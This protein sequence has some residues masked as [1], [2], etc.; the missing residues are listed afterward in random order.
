MKSAAIYTTFLRSCRNFREFGSA[1]KHIQDE[2]LTFEEAR[3]AC[4][5]FNSHLSE[6]QQEAGTK[7][8]FTTAD[9]I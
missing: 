8:E 2:G 6:A 1:E 3:E 9:N 7:M 5:E 4:Q